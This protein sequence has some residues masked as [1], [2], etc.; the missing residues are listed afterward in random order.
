MAGVRDPSSSEAAEHARAI[1]R[2]DDLR[3]SKL[4]SQRAARSVAE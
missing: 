1:A 3:G 4:P 2:I